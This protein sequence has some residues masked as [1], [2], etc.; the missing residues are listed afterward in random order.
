MV[1]ETMNMAI[2]FIIKSKLGVVGTEN[3]IP[4]GGSNR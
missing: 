1:N 2:L 4:Y 3:K